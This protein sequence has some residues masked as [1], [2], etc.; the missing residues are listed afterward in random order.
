[1]HTSSKR[2]LGALAVGAMLLAGC[3]GSDDSTAGSA[4][5][6][7]SDFPAANGDSLEQ[8]LTN[9]S[10]QGPVVAPAGQVYDLGKNR[11]SFGVFTPGRDPISDAQVA[12]YTAPG[13]N[14][15]AEGPFPARVESLE[16]DPAFEAKTTADD[17]DAATTVY[18]SDLDFDRKGEWRIV[19]LIKTGDTYEA[20][21]VPSAVVNSDPI[22][23]VGQ[24]APLM[25]TLTADDVGGDVS[26]IDTRVPHDDMH[27]DDLAD[28]L[29]RK[30]VV[31][32]FATPALCQSRVCG[33]V[34]DEAEQ[35]KSQYGDRVAFIHQEIYNDNDLNK[36]LRPQVKDYAL[37]TE[38]WLFVID[39][40]GKVSTR[41]EGAFSV[42]ELQKAVEKVAGPPN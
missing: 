19:A 15:K 36:G 22:P 4:A 33:P 8:V 1:M 38:P 16:T 39:K 28:V 40:Q 26:Q 42:P 20:S 34:V 21:R 27:N 12:L 25:H 37:Q 23:Q 14:G 10:A 2:A 32:L 41:I 18:V 30:P 7:T 31:L 17:P 11:Y 9:A 5:P 24:K 29:G 3:G 35:V 6:S 13:Q